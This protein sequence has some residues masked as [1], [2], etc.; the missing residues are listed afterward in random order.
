MIVCVDGNDGTGKTSLIARLRPL[1]PAITFQ[2]RGLPTAM[3][4]GRTAPP[5]DRYLILH[6]SVETCQRRLLAAG[7]SL[8]EPYHTAADLT[9]YGRRFLEVAAALGATVIDAEREQEAIVAG[10]VELLARW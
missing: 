2:D 3:T 5:A 9:H 8:D 10:V 6:A 4:D 1:L 7:K